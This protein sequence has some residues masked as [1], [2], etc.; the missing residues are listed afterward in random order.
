[1]GFGGSF[2][3]FCSIFFS[4]SV[5]LLDLLLLTSDWVVMYG[6]CCFLLA[7]FLLVNSTPFDRNGQPFNC[8]VFHTYTECLQWM[9]KFC[10]EGT[11]QF[12]RFPSKLFTFNSLSSRFESMMFRYLFTFEFSCVSFGNH[13]RIDF[14]GLSFY[15]ACFY[16][17]L[18]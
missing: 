7:A 9:D 2:F 6:R 15:F 12:K 17:T 1:M 11:I 5:R 10:P 18:D 3:S 14:F 16:R 13:E 8:T 4:S